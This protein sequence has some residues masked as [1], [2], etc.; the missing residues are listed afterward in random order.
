[1]GS[2]LFNLGFIGVTQDARPF[3]R[4]WQER[5]RRDALIDPAQQLFTDQR[6]VD[7]VP[8]LFDHTVLR[9][10]GLNV[11]YWN[12]HERDLHRGV[13]GSLQA[14]DVPLRFFHFSGYDP[15]RPWQLSRHAARR[16]R[17]HLTDSRVLQDLCAG[18]SAD[19]AGHDHALTRT[20]PY[21]LDHLS[22]GMAM[23]PTLRRLIRT[24]YV[25]GESVANPHTDPDGFRRWLSQPVHGTPAHPLTRWDLL[26]WSDREDLRLGYPDVEGADA[27]AFRR[28]LHHD[29]EVT[30]SAEHIFGP[31]PGI[32]R[33][34]RPGST[35]GWS[36]LAYAD[37]ELGV[38]EAGRR[39]ARAVQQ[40]GTPVEVVGVD[41]TMSRREHQHRLEVRR[42]PSFANTISCVNA[43][44]LAQVWDAVG[45]SGPGTRI[46]LWF[47][48]VDR[49]PDAWRPR[50]ADLDQL[51]VTSEQA[52]R[53]FEGIG[54]CPVEQIRLPVVARPAPTPHT[55]AALGLPE[56]RFTFLCCFDFLSVLRRKNPLDVLASYT[57]AFGPDDGAALVVKS[58]NGS[59]ARE[60]LALVLAAAG[61]RS[62]VTVI[63]GYRTSG[64]VA[65]MIEL[66]DCLVSLHR[67]E[68]YGLNLVDAMTVGTPVVAT[69]YSGN[70]S[71]M[72]ADSAFLV[73]YDEVPVGPG[74]D[75]YPP[76]AHWAQP[77]LDVAS[78]L[79][80][81]VFDDPAAARERGR[82]GQQKVLRENTIEVVGARIRELTRD[83]LMAAA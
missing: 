82:I 8:S 48:E 32:S 53:L 62:D 56:D 74:C 45:V 54:L 47:W 81:R 26:V 67:S 10:P 44:R 37:A 40:L 76:E 1:M 49:F 80:R 22:G 38:G 15:D 43:D 34:T 61:G 51:W 16:P 17:V 73:P 12:V 39:L 4:W 2:G 79:L 9:D 25:N 14:G 7:W 28:W 71:F 42:T 27:A 77:D 69:G 23:T 57:Q 33:S 75:P 20:D 65:G 60:E 66:S 72:D 24:A 64:E 11:A 83:L 52:R 29:F 5:L 63:D 3:L 41:G 68:G 6:W 21:R 19:L 58:I 70:L 35:V 59:L 78:E 13:D 30:R 55:R 46:G 36:L 18:Y 31:P 50:L